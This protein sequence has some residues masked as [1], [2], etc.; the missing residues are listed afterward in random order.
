MLMFQY[1]IAGALGIAAGHLKKACQVSILFLVYATQIR[2][3]K[4]QNILLQMSDKLDF[5]TFAD[6]LL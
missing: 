6:S 5:V 2:E 4:L 3:K 1:I